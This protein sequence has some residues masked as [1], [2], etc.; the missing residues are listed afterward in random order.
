[1]LDQ[2]GKASSRSKDMFPCRHYPV[3]ESD[4]GHG[5][6][7]TQAA[8]IRFTGKVLKRRPVLAVAS[9]GEGRACTHGG[10]SVGSLKITCCAS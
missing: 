8:L 7:D 5:T 1:M 6:E 9:G 4:L 3:L 2:E 10:M